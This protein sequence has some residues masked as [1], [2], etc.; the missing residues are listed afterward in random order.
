MSTVRSVHSIRVCPVAHLVTAYTQFLFLKHMQPGSSM[1]FW[2]KIN[3]LTLSKPWAILAFSLW[4]FH[5][6]VRLKID[7]LGSFTFIWKIYWWCPA[8]E[9]LFFM[10]ICVIDLEKDRSKFSLWDPPL[11]LSSKGR[12]ISF[13]WNIQMISVAVGKEITQ[14]FLSRNWDNY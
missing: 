9:A 8:G 13:E 5:F 6:H 3:A 7:P 10:L 2:I 1:A 11:I 4:L 12:Y 14:N